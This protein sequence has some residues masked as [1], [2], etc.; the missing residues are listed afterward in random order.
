MIDKNLCKC[1]C[2]CEY[3]QKQINKLL[4]D[5][6]EATANLLNQVKSKKV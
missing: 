6:E 1:V 4:A 5:M 3:C 2:P